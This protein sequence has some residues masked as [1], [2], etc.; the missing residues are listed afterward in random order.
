MGTE[1]SISF[2]HAGSLISPAWLLP[3]ALQGLSSA[4]CS[5]DL[6][7]RGRETKWH[8]FRDTEGRVGTCRG[9]G[10]LWALDLGTAFLWR[11]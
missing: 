9:D 5:L 6:G 11:F 7:S 1:I 4:D 8:F 3:N 10:S 2:R